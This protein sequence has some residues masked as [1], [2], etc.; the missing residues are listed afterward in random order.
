MS[1][2][3]IRKGNQKI[4]PGSLWAFLRLIH[5]SGK[6]L[7]CVVQPRGVRK[8][9]QPKDVWLWAVQCYA[10]R[11]LSLSPEL[12]WFKSGR[13]PS[14]LCDVCDGL[15][16]P[17]RAAALV[18]SSDRGLFHP[19]DLEKWI[20]SFMP[21][22]VQSQHKGP[23]LEWTKGGKT[24]RTVR[25]FH[26][27][28][29]V[30]VWGSEH[31]SGDI[32]VKID[33]LCSSWSQVHLIIQTI[34]VC[35]GLSYYKEIAF[36]WHH[37]PGYL[38]SRESVFTLFFLAELMPVPGWLLTPEMSLPGIYYLGLLGRVRLQRSRDNYRT[39]C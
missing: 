27:R 34:D 4:A 5:L 37:W 38:H 32:G 19:L 8:F 9:S 28:G 12:V 13:I 21:T 25:C 17:P 10:A 24:M 20:Y 31:K 35:Q 16:C 33:S 15:T 39:W 22:C 7:G 2:R 1:D 14:K 29:G 18:I 11:S 26:H 3:R 23:S 36:L 30:C 6:V